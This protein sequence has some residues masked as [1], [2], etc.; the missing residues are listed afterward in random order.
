MGKHYLLA[1]LAFTMAGC[2]T[3]RTLQ[4]TGGSRA[5]GVVEM[6]MELG[7]LE[8][9]RVD[10]SHAQAEATLR[11]QAWGYQFAQKFGGQ[12][13]VCQ[14]PGAYMC[15][16]TLVTVAYQCTDSPP[17]KRTAAAG[18]TSSTPKRPASGQ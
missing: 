8:R 1:L 12:K 6:S 11:C 17:T 16:R 18:A 15:E 10:W 2:T 14:Q 3:D 7:G 5:D 9:A 4:A 13:E